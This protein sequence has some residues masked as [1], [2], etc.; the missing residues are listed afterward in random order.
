[1]DND[2]TRVRIAVVD[3]EPD[4]LKILEHWLKGSYD[5]VC[6]RGGPRTAD[7]VAALRPDL[8]VLDI[9]MPPP[10]GF[11]VCRDLRARPG[12]GRLPVLFLTG[13]N[14]DEDFLKHL[15][16]GGSRYLTKPIERDKLLAAVAD[17]LELARAGA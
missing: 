6:L 4:F 16:A 11:S 15:E 17:E 7:E 12:L 8:V 14:S 9:H 3:D 5:V 13:S 1:M 2:T 10:D